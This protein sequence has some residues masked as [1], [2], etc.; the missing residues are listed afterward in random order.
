MNNIANKIV[1]V[2]QAKARALGMDLCSHDFACRVVYDDV[3]DEGIDNIKT[4][5]RRQRK[6]LGDAAIWDAISDLRR[7]GRLEYDCVSGALKVRG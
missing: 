3:A 5:F 7:Q 4:L 2:V 6:V 1:E